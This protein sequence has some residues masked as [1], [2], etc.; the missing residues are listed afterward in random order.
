MWTASPLL[1][2]TA[3]LGGARCVVGSGA[4][5]H[6]TV[7]TSRGPRQLSR[8]VLSSS[9]SSSPRS[10]TPTQDFVDVLD[11]G[12]VGDNHTD[13]TAAFQ[14][15]I[16]AAASLDGIAVY[17]PS[18][19]YVFEGNLTLPPGV[20][21]Q[22]S[23]ASVPSHQFPGSDTPMTDGTVLIPQ[24][25]R[26]VPCDIDCTSAFISVHE[27]AAVR[28]LVIYYQQQERVN[29]P[30]AYPWSLFLS[31]NNAAVEDVELLGAW[32]GVAAVAAH[33]HYIARVQVRSRGWI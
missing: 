1:L 32:N 11:Y 4:V 2:V 25:G 33:R 10:A 6:N 16:N 24:G 3:L 31:G 5:L 9:S 19:M 12:A 15:A 26:G 29:T 18:G 17:V 8:R 14:A 23:Y 28:G 20:A 7:M 21:L 27:N 22:G 30:V 13:N